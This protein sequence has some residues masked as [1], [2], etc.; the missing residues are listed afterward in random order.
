MAFANGL[1]G[2]NEVFAHEARIGLQDHIDHIDVS[3]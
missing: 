2:E 3:G 1:G